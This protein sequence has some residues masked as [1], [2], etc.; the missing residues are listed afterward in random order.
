MLGLA[1]CGLGIKGAKILA[2]CNPTRF[3]ALRVLY[4][5]ENALGNAGTQALASAPLLRSLR[6]LTLDRN[7]IRTAGAKALAESPH[8]DKLELL[9]V[10]G[11][12][13]DKEGVQPLRKRFG[14]R[15]QWYGDE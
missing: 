1:C 9:Y 8:L 15:L 14:E 13:I 12:P 4:L 3:P 7:N 5:G 10:W 2:S 11:N 6:E